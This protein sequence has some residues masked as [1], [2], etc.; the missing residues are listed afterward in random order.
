MEID[1]LQLFFDVG[2][3]VLIWMIQLIVYPSFSFY[4]MDA[5]VVWHKKY[6]IRLSI[7]VIPLMFGQLILSG[8]Q[9]YVSHTPETT[10]RLLLVLAVWISTFSQF[11]PIHALIAQQKATRRHL[12]QL[13]KRNWIRTALWTLI[14]FWS[15][16]LMYSK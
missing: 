6:T 4:E 15:I 8:W 16:F 11:V 2:L 14:C 10:I 3:F 1:V 12:Q 9:W 13:V 5:L 7:I